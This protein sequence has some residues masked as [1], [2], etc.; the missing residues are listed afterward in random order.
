MVGAATI[1]VMMTAQQTMT[2]MMMAG[3]AAAGMTSIR[4]VSQL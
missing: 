2:A 4:R 3:I 1:A